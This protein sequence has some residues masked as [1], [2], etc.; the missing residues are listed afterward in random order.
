[1]KKCSTSGLDSGVV[2]HPRCSRRHPAKVLN[3]L[4]FIDDI[5]M[6][7]PLGPADQYLLQVTVRDARQYKHE[8]LFGSLNVCGEAPNYPSLQKSTCSTQ[9]VRLFSFVAANPGYYHKI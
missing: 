1:M 2:T 9:P 5:A 4:D 7:Y 8:V 3:D 6:L